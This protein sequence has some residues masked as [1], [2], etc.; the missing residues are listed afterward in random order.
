MNVATQILRGDAN[1]IAFVQ[2]LRT[3]ANAG[4]PR[5]KASLSTVGIAFFAQRY[6]EVFAHARAHYDLVT[7]PNAENRRAGTLELAHVQA[8]AR[9]RDP[10][11]QL[12][13]AILRVLHGALRRPLPGGA[14]IGYHPMPRMN[15]PG[16]AFGN[17]VFPPG[18]PSFPVPVIPGL[19]SFPAFPGTY[20]IPGYPPFTPQVIADLVGVIQRA[21]MA[22]PMPY[23][24]PMMSSPRDAEPPIM[25]TMPAPTGTSPL[26]RIT[27]TTLP[28]STAPSTP[29]SRTVTEARAT[30]PTYSASLPGGLTPTQMYA[31]KLSY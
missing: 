5:A 14:Q 23:Q 10:Q 4:D 28:T 2:R 7:S 15:R 8:R 30:T 22:Y 17:V 11:A 12:Q 27:R 29:W 1:A 3:L 13:L 24:P 31:Q 25:S 26:G 9:G 18:Y 20:Q 6:P 16:V 21:L 19:P